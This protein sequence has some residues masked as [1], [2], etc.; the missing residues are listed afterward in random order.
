MENQEYSVGLDIG[1]TKI[2]A[3]VGRR[4]AHGKIEILGVGKAKSLGVHK[5]IV[6][7]ISQTINS[8]KSAV[9]EAQSS[10]GVPITKVTVG[11]AGKHIRSLQHSDYIMRDHPDQYITEEDIEKLKDQVKK[12]VMLPGEEIIHVLPQDYKVDSEGEI[13]EPVGMHGKRLE[14]N[15]HVVVG[16]MGSIR[17][18]AR[19]VREAGLEMEA[20][21]LE[22]L[23]S[24]EAVLTKEEKEA[25]VAI[26]DIGGGTTDIA[27]FKDNIIRHT[28]VIPYGG[29]I[30][31]DD[32]KEGCSIIEKHAEQLKV[33][34][35]SSVPEL[36]KD[37]TYVTIPGL[38][39]RPDKE[40]SLKVLAQIINARVEEILEMVNTELKAYGAFEQ[41]KKLIAGIV[42]TGGG[43]NLRNLRQLANYTTGFDSRIGFANEYVA[44]DKNQYLKGPEFAT[45]IG[46]L[47]E[48]LKIRDK[49]MLVTEEEIIEELKPQ[50]ENA[51]QAQT[52]SQEIQTPQVQND[53]VE[54][55]KHKAE[56]KKNRPTFGQSLMDKVKK[57]FEEVEE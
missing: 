32:I 21:T 11:I 52:Q 33:K 25:G 47:M 13:Q 2:V 39:G 51:I 12:L 36:E 18:I 16:Q 3:I 24:S 27:I 5:G 22:P 30:I 54:I 48:S 38:H 7:N 10:A 37:S 6:N 28:C 53:I 29:G 45:S 4:N 17:N 8:I 20:L 34:F 31:T 49:K 41:K 23:A 42:L 56:V 26:V 9:A 14:A 43:S 50:I 19:C 46:L 40:I 57:F 15:F 55:A 1:T 44:N 35:G